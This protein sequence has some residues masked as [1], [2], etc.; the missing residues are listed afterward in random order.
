M[1]NISQLLVVLWFPQ[2]QRCSTIPSWNTFV[3]PMFIRGLLFLPCLTQTPCNILSHLCF[4]W[5]DQSWISFCD[6][7]FWFHPSRTQGTWNSR[8]PPKLLPAKQFATRYALLESL[9]Q[10]LLKQM[11]RTFVERDLC[12][13]VMLSLGTCHNDLGAA[14]WCCSM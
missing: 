5:T 10:W 6:S 8:T 4:L 3:D 1:L 13:C 2:N 9:K 12:V 7:F 14:C 11:R